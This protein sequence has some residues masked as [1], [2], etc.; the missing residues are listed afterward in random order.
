MTIAHSAGRSQEEEEEE[1]LTMALAS[2][3]SSSFSLCDP[4]PPTVRSKEGGISKGD[5]ISLLFF[6]LLCLGH[7]FFLFLFLLP[8]GH[9]M[10]RWKREGA[11]IPERRNKKG[12]LFSW[13]VALLWEG[14][15]VGVN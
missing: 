12:L 14:E 6:F 4:D 2:S 5:N 7:I 13:L 8:V 9:H 11:R 10:V 3:S 1:V 15:T